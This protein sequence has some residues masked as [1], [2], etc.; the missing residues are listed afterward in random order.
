MKKYLL[1]LLALFFTLPSYAVS[2]F[3]GS[4]FCQQGGHQVLTAGNPPS[5]TKV[6]ESYPFCTVTV[7]ITGTTTKPLLFKDDAGTLPLSNPFVAD[8]KGYYS[9]YVTLG[10]FDLNFSGSTITQPFT[11]TQITIGNSGALT[12]PITVPQG[13]SGSVNPGTGVLLGNGLAPFTTELPLTVPHGGIGTVNPGTGVL[14]GNATGPVSSENP[15][16]VPHGGL[17]A[18]SLTGILLGNGAAPVSALPSIDVPHGGTGLNSVVAG[19]LLFGN[20]AGALGVLPLPPSTGQTNYL[21]SSP[22]VATPGLQYSPPRVLEVP[23]FNFPAITPGGTLT[24]AVVATVILP[25]T[26][27]GV[28]GA[29]QN[30]WL[31]I[32]G[33]TGAAEPVVIVGGT[34]II[35]GSG[36][37]TIQ[38]TP[39]N[40]HSGAWTIVSAT[41]GIQEAINQ[42]LNVTNYSVH[43]PAGTY[44]LYAPVAINATAQRT[45]TFYGDGMGYFNN[46]AGTRII[47]NGTGVGFSLVGDLVNNGCEAAIT[48][49]NFTLK[50]SP[51]SNT[52][53]SASNTCMLRIDHVFQVESRTYGLSCAPNCYTLEVSHSYFYSNGLEGIFLQSAVN[54]VHLEYIGIQ[55]NCRQAAGVPCNGIT[56]TSAAQNALAVSITKSGFALDGVLPIAGFPSQSYEVG[57]FDVKAFTFSENYCEQPLTGCLH[58]GSPSRGITISGNYMQQGGILIDSNVTGIVI[59]GNHL[60]SGSVVQSISNITNSGGFCRITLAAPPTNGPYTVGSFVAISGATGTTSCNDNSFD[61]AATVQSVTSSTV[62]TTGRPFTGG[63]YGGSGTASRAGG[64]SIGGG[65][66]YVDA[67]VF[68]NSLNFGDGDIQQIGGD[69]LPGFGD[70]ITAATTIFPNHAFHVISGAGTIDNIV[71]PS[72]YAGQFCVVP[73]GAWS[74]STFGNIAVAFTATPNVQ[75]C[76]TYYPSTSRWY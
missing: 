24:S 12:L 71:G 11:L 2:Y 41:D 34:C 4:G 38:F 16:T 56:V 68:G 7:F 22:N 19:G 14:L 9:F 30:H 39:A 1:L 72:G 67:H 73:T 59:S 57:V 35:G 18:S 33:G 45:Q 26:P 20:N 54:E 17:G 62:F 37:C 76:W 43:A 47:N 23:D 8:S 42:S 29:D 52:G 74:T 69:L 55:A 48:L 21:R 64:Y 50:G 53:I 3:H 61:T 66:N 51:T 60:T 70:P 15:L 27:L 75:K 31:R 46:I 40:S 32:V 49:R 36:A 25:Y 63:V 6:Q 58:V 65:A 28:A 5:T 10:V 44:N 13:G